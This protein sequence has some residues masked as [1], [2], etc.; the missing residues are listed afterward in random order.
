MR[1]PRWKESEE[2]STSLIASCAERL[3]AITEFQRSVSWLARSLSRVIPALW[4]TMS[5]PPC[6][7][8]CA[9]I[10][11]A[12][13][14]PVMSSCSAVPPTELAVRASASPAAGMST[15]TTVAPSRASVEATVAP[16][17]RAAPGDDGDL[18][19][20][21]PIPVH[22]LRGTRE[23][24]DGS[25]VDPLPVDER[26]PRGQEEPQRRLDVVLGAVGD[27]HQVGRGA[28]AG[29]LGR[30][31]H[32]APRGSDAR[33]G[34]PGRWPRRAHHRSRGCD[35]SDRPASSPG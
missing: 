23:A 4:T 15:Q 2:I 26:R 27:V 1:P 21:G 30:R 9:R 12:A 32:E 10:V 25:D 19:R 24:G 18:P 8:A 28:V 5:I 29:F 35:R 20:E 34:R 16:M 7:A 22:A 14:V 3:T 11:D 31:T 6:R 33:R 13:P 17:P